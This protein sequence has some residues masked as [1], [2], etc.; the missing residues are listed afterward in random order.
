MRNENISKR[1]QA[2]FRA[3]FNFCCRPHAF[4]L[5]ASMEADAAGVAPISRI[6]A[7]RML[8]SRRRVFKTDQS[9]KRSN[10]I[11]RERYSSRHLS[12]AGM[13]R[14]VCIRSRVSR[15]PFQRQVLRAGN[16]E[17]SFNHV[18]PLDMHLIRC[19]AATRA[20]FAA[21]HTCGGS[22]YVFS[23]R[24]NRP[25]F[26]DIIAIRCRYGFRESDRIGLP[27]NAV[28]RNPRDIGT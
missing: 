22:T 23:R 1:A 25:E 5:F 26:R 4:L 20:D 15:A 7:A 14:G 6:V 17:E 3:Y 19:A 21:G 27:R 28:E 8:I 13:P 12:A 11:A 2:V 16:Y 24:A 10:G 18:L 9:H